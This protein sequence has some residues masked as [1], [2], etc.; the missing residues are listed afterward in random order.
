MNSKK[1]PIMHSLNLG[2]NTH[3]QE[4]K[5][6]AY[7]FDINKKFGFGKP[8][9]KKSDSDQNRVGRVVLIKNIFESPYDDRAIKNKFHLNLKTLQRS[10]CY[11]ILK[12]G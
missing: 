12:T 2:A 10:S 5:T 11:N 6:L 1:P 9:K 3:S 7:E 4:R 8:K